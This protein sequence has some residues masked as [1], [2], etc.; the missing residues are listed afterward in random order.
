M[1]VGVGISAMSIVFLDYESSKRLP[2]TGQQAGLQTWARQDVEYKAAGANHQRSTQYRATAR[3]TKVFPFGLRR[4]SHP[5]QCLSRKPKKKK[6]PGTTRL[7]QQ[8][9]KHRRK[10]RSCRRRAS[11]TLPHIQKQTFKQKAKHHVHPNFFKQTLCKAFAF[12]FHRPSPFRQ[13]LSQQTKRYQGKHPSSQQT[14]RYRGT[15]R[16]PQQSRR[17]RRRS[18]SCR[19]KATYCYY[20]CWD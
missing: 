16:L 18:S 14:K 12:A 6:H 19:R 15:T 7:P 10:S 3:S 4:P 8:S 5:L 13:A 1:V 9:E 17:H 2:S 11:Q 20:S